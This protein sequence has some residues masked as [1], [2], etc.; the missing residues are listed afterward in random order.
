M[1]PDEVEKAID[2]A[3]WIIVWRSRAQEA[4][5]LDP[6]LALLW[7]HT[8]EIYRKVLVSLAKDGW[9]V[10]HDLLCKMA[11]FLTEIGDTLPL[12]LQEYIV[13]VAAKGRMRRAKKGRDPLANL[14]RNL[15]IGEAVKW[16]CRRYGLR[17]T[18]N[19]ATDIQCG[20]S[21]VAMALEGSGADMSEANVAAIWLKQDFSPP[22][23]DHDQYSPTKR[24][25]GGRSRQ[26]H[27]AR[28]TRSGG[29]YL[30]VGRRSDRPA[31]DSGPG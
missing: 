28:H 15:V 24:S 19:P 16:V 21:I 3:K 6:A 4:Y 20:S 12:W 14:L 27:G 23:D 13:L 8:K 7:C 22:A 11:F 17:P 25:V 1:T 2:Y 10:G 5:L 9:D 26:S 18:R 29:G 31:H 30:R